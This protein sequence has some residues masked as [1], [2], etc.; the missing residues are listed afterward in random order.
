MYH[1]HMRAR[2]DQDRCQGHNRCVALAPKL[3]EIDDYGTASAVGDGA[4]PDDLVDDALLA[5]DN[6]PEF[7]IT[8]TD[9]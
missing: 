6:C 8:I 7:A 2:V 4:I 1:G 9:D 5:A 3:F